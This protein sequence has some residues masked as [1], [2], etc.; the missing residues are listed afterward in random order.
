MGKGTGKAGRVSTIAGGSTP[1]QKAD[2]VEYAKSDAAIRDGDVAVEVS[3]SKLEKAWSGDSMHIPKGGAGDKQKYASARGY[4]Q[5]PTKGPVKMARVT[6]KG[7]KAS[8]TDG[9]HRTAAIR[10]LGKRRVWITVPR[11]QAKAAKKNL[12]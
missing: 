12:G 8:I 1:V 3:V 10:D 7:G 5:K 9:R 2:G 6:I 11:S 4:V